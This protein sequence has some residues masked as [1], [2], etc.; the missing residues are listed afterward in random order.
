MNTPRDP[1]TVD[2]KHYVNEATLELLRRRLEADVRR[3][4]WSWVG[5]PVGG[6]GLVGVLYVLFSAIPS[7][8]GD[9]IATDSNVQQRMETAVV[10]YLQDED[11]GGELIRR[12]V[13]ASSTEMVNRAVRHYF[14]SEAGRNVLQAGIDRVVRDYYEGQEGRQ[15]VRELVA[16]YM[17]SQ[18]V[19][20]QIRQ[21]VETA[22]QPAVAR[23]QDRIESNLAALVVEIAEVPVSAQ[24]DKAQMSRLHE[25]LQGPEARR[26]VASGQPITLDLSAGLGPRYA[27]FTIAE[28]IQA[29]RQTF[30][31]Q[32]R[33]VLIKDPEGRF[34]ALVDAGAVLQRL[35]AG[36]MDVVNAR[37]DEMP[38]EEA[39]ARLEALFGDAV[40]LRLSTDATAAAALRA[41][42]WRQVAP[43][44]PVAVTDPS[45]RFIGVTT[46]QSLIEGVLG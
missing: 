10:D 21:A 9:F 41:P 32:F 30:G 6:A 19:H 17:N 13:E 22:L 46:R 23:L 1:L 7:Y 27:A 14:A 24:F 16:E 34:L 37:R 43:T 29:F 31:E 39:V 33:H 18:T 28:H 45:G 11:T 44:A 20:A 35:D 38:A 36:F 3:S 4:F 25:F 26:I 2:D 15:K 8:V 40:S 5:L 12:Q 42:L